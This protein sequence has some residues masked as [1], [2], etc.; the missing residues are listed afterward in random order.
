M[1]STGMIP[2]EH[3][4]RVIAMGE[5]RSMYPIRRWKGRSTVFV[6]YLGLLIAVFHPPHG[7]G[8]T[9]CWTKLHCGIPCPGCGLCRSLSCAARGMLMESVSYHAFGPVLLALF[10]GLIV[11]RYVPSRVSAR[12]DAAAAAHRR[13]FAA[14]YWAFTVSFVLYGAGRALLHIRAAWS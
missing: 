11:A 13:L 12:L 7:L 9:I 4:S 8:V 6:A 3:H 1:D 2:S 14:A 10:A 5:A